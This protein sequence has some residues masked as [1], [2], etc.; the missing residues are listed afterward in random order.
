MSS[1]L[2]TFK[3]NLPVIRHWGYKFPSRVPARPVLSCTHV[4]YKRLLRRLL[5]HLI[6]V[7]ECNLG[8]VKLETMLASCLSLQFTRGRQPWAFRLG[9]WDFNAIVL[10]SSHFARVVLLVRG[11]ESETLPSLGDFC[12]HVSFQSFTWGYLKN[13]CLHLIGW[14]VW[15]CSNILFLSKESQVTHTKRWVN[16]FW[17]TITGKKNT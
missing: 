13:A 17:N 3:T 14:W 16:L 1:Y 5:T 4:K 9:I 10:R 15:L 12:R 7:A 6:Y 11:P 2:L 8:K